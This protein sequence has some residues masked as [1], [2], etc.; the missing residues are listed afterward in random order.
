MLW[1]WGLPTFVRLSRTVELS[2]NYLV[3]IPANVGAMSALLEL[4]L[5]LNPL[6]TSLP[7]SLSSLTNLMSLGLRQCQLVGTLPANMSALAALTYV[8]GFGCVAVPLGE[9]SC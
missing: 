7:P 1:G 8:D 2:Q 6:A 5:S 9:C 4:D 3:G